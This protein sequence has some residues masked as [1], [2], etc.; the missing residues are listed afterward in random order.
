MRLIA[1]HLI[2]MVVFLAV[3]NPAR[4]AEGRGVISKIDLAKNQILLEGKG[5]LRDRT[6]PFE[7]TKDTK[8]FFGSEEFHLSDLAV[9][10]RVIIIFDERASANVALIIKVSGPKPQA[11]QTPLTESS[12]AKVLLLAIT[13]REMVVE[14]RTSQ[15][16]E[17]EVTYIVPRDVKITREDKPIAIDQIKEGDLVFVE[18]QARDHKQEARS[19]RI[20]GTAP[21]ANAVDKKKE[22]RE[23]ALK[24]LG[25]ILQKFMGE[26]PLKK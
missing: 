24:V 26:N 20:G 12:G 11:K 15:G 19:I 7:L 17:N 6:I 10:K 9:G 16:A 2:V 8:V 1:K 21:V 13:A 3:A 5:K 14:A 25:Q 4:T 22:K 18:A 23:E